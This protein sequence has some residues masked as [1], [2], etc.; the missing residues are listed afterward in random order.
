MPGA[1]HLHRHQPRARRRRRSDPGRRDPWPAALHPRPPRP[2]SAAGHAR[3]LHRP[4]RSGLRGRVRRRRARVHPAHLRSGDDGHR[5][6]RRRHRRQA[7]LGTGPRARR[8]LAGT[9][10]GRPHPPR[11]G[12]PEPRSARHDRVARQRP[13]RRRPGRGERRL[14]ATP[15]H[16]GRTLVHP[17]PGPGAD[18]RGAPG[19]ARRRVDAIRGDDRRT[20]EGRSV[21]RA[22]RGGSRGRHA[23]DSAVSQEE[24]LSALPSVIAVTGASGHL[25]RAV[26]DALLA[27]DEVHRIVCIDRV[28]FPRDDA[29]LH[30]VTRDIRDPALAKELEGCETVVHLAFIVEVGSRDASEVESINID[31]SQN[32]FDAAVA[33]GVDHLVHLSS[34]SAYGFHAENAD[35]MLT[36]DAPLRGNDDFYYSRTKTAV[37]RL[38]DEVQGRVP[39]L[40]I[41]RL[42]PTTFL[43]TRS[44]R[45]TAASLFG[46]LWIASS[47]GPACQMLH[48]DDVVDALVKVLELRSTGAFNLA[49]R[50]ALPPRE[51]G[52]ALDKPTITLPVWLID[53]LLALLYFL[54]LS[55]MDPQWL[56]LSNRVAINVD[57]TRAR[58]ELGWQPRHD[59]TRDALRAIAGLEP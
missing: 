28:P 43:A 54:R 11:C 35:R 46:P 41:C 7:A 5:P 16:H 27:R 53:R 45:V 19:P 13:R 30:S 36:E 6:G 48:Q 49:P 12:R 25:G 58:D 37:E 42:R 55:D 51:W 38:L 56:R 22:H 3:R 24:R 57:A 1:A 4:G 34:V 8:P 21:C 2:G 10:R 9:R 14:L 52:Y 15:E 47:T 20:A 23:V 29:R 40:R 18:A 50:D 39:A 33:A 17:L 44:D 59:T 26:V 32:V 31:G